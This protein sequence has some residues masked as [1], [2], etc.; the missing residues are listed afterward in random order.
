MYYNRDIYLHVNIFV[1]LFLP[2]FSHLRL[3]R[4]REGPG[5]DQRG[6]G[7]KNVRQSSRSSRFKFSIVSEFVN[8]RDHVRSFRVF[9]VRWK[10]R[11][12]VSPAKEVTRSWQAFCMIESSTSV[13]R[14]RSRKTP[15]PRAIFKGCAPFNTPTI[16][17][18]LDAL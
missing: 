17:S 8:Q 4:L 14:G 10:T 9:V 16:F 5:C 3:I 15:Y 6:T 13:L 1:I 18:F 12:F 11:K 2:P 7:S